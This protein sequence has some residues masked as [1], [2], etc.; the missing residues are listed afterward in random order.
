MYYASTV[1]STELATDIY[2]NDCR[3]PAGHATVTRIGC[4]VV[5]PNICNAFEAERLMMQDLGNHQIRS[6]GSITV[7]MCSGRCSVLERL[8]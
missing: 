8:A 2:H 4:R 6:A 7:A 1:S 3:L 5:R